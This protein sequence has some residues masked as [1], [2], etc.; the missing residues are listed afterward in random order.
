MPFYRIYIPASNEFKTITF[1]E[2]S[3]FEVDEYK[4]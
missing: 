1:N 4:L 2:I 3:S